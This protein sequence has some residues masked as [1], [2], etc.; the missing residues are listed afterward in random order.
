MKRFY[1]SAF[2]AVLMG[3]AIAWAI[4]ISRAQAVADHIIFSSAF[5][6]KNVEVDVTN[7]MA[8]LCNSTAT[9]TCV[10]KAQL[11]LTQNASSCL[12]IPEGTDDFTYKVVIT[13]T[14]VA[15]GQ[16]QVTV[17][18]VMRFE[19]NVAPATLGTGTL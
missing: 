19:P 15:T 18:P 14:D 7:A 9:T 11:C 3:L 10:R 1:F 2:A 5:S 16:Q 12:D 6:F 8:S 17:L 13:R 4:R